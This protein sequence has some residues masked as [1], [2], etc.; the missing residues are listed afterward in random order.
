MQTVNVTLT[1]PAWTKLTDSSQ[2]FVL[3]GSA[4]KLIEVALTDAD[5]APSSISGHALVI[6]PGNEAINRGSIGSGYVWAR[7][8]LPDAT[9]G[10]F[11][12][13]TK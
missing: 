2:D 8:S 1:T 10:A 3:S 12:V 4:R 6:G 11:V 9:A 5:A 7:L 13:L